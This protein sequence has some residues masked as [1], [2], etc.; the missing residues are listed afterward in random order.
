M[1][2]YYRLQNEVLH[3]FWSREAQWQE[4][5]AQLYALSG[6]QYCITDLSTHSSNEQRR[7]PVLATAGWGGTRRAGPEAGSRSG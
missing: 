2:K 5:T 6:T 1:R 3:M 7:T 4:P